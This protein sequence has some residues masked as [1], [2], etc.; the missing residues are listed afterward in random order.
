MSR[1]ALGRGLAEIAADRGLRIVGGYS[2][3]GQR[4]DFARTLAA[5]AAEPAPRVQSADGWTRAAWARTANL[6]NLALHAE[7][8]RLRGEIA[9][10]DRTIRVLRADAEAARAGF[11]RERTALEARAVDAARAA[12][13]EALRTARHGGRLPSILAVPGR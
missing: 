12:R 5:Y 6:A 1:P 2:P 13:H 10:R 8:E 7:L 11:E 3:D 9:E 4:A